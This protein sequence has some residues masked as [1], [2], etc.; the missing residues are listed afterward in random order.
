MSDNRKN[1]SS[2]LLTAKKAEVKE[3][4]KFFKSI[5]DSRVKVLISTKK[6]S[7][8]YQEKMSLIDRQMRLM[9]IKMDEVKERVK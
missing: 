2:T 6:Q 9:K 5:L 7:I 3:K 4:L 1:V 8:K